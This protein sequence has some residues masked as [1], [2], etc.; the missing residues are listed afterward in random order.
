MNLAVWTQDEAGPF[1]TIPM[2][3]QSWQPKG[4]AK[5]QEHEYIRNGT[6][7]LMTLFCPSSGEVRAEGVTTCPNTVLHPWLKAE[8]TKILKTLPLV[9]RLE[10]ELNREQWRCWQEGL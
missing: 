5:H 9:G 3:G 2:P 4:T 7:K 10:P 1:Q 8:L 6:A